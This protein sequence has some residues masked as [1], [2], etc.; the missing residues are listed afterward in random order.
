M[1]KW[2]IKRGIIKER[3]NEILFLQF[4]DK[5]EKRLTNHFLKCYFT[6]Y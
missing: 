4:M 1:F 3:T 2:A 5:I 6:A